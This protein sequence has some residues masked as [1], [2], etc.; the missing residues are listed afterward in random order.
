MLKKA[1]ELAES[2]GETCSFQLGSAGQTLAVTGCRSLRKT[3]L[4]PEIQNY[5]KLTRHLA[6]PIRP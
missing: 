3:I 1:I 5:Q 4:E 6:A 2:D